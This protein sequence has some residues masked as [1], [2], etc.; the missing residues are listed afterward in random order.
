M[1]AR[2][3]AFLALREGGDRSLEAVSYFAEE[4]ELEPRD[5]GLARKIVGT[6]QR[7]RGCLRAI[8]N[9][10]AYPKPKA[11]LATMLH[12]GLAQLFYL[13]RVPNH[14][15]VSET[16]LATNNFIGQAKGRVIN[17]VLRKVLRTRREELSGDPTR[18]LIGTNVSFPIPL[19]R[20]PAEHF[21]L[22]VEDAL[23]IPSALFKAWD[24]RHGRERALQLAHWA[25]EEPPLSV[26]PASGE[27]SAL[28]EAFRGAGI[29]PLHTGE[30]T[31]LFSAEQASDVLQSEV[32]KEQRAVVQGAA[33]CAAA[34]LV[35]A[36]ADQRI[37]DL[38]AAPGGKATLMAASGARVLAMDIS[39]WRLLRVWDNLEAQDAERTPW[40]VASDGATAL[41]PE[42]TFDAVL[43]D[44][45][46]S[47]T[48]VLA[49][50]PEARWRFGPQTKKSLTELQARLLDQA[51]PHVRPGGALVYSTCS[52]EPA[53]NR[54]QAKAFIERQGGE[55]AWTLEAEAEHLPDVEQGFGD[56]GYAARLRRRD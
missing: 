30:H 22:W 34:K 52:L 10:V 17:A 29:E 26:R 21:Y 15:A 37:L 49:A 45:P 24:Q 14:A 50:R 36:R 42:A 4:Y 18:D 8:V 44:A 48:G 38:C 56:G 9:A 46:C 39:D 35:D 54:A 40:V 55:S 25:G 20:D 27:V 16:V 19:F 28:A 1:S 41:R 6:V 2:E 13:D 32:F 5:A 43:L 7:R 11:E 23:S 53:E 51:A 3:V 47:N 12:I 33:A 31:L